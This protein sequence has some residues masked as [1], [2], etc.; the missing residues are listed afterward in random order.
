MT[1][2]AAEIVGCAAA[3]MT[4]AAQADQ[5]QP[6]LRALCLPQIEQVGDQ[7]NA[8]KITGTSAVPAGKVSFYFRWQDATTGVGFGQ[9]AQPNYVAP[10]WTPVTVS[11]VS[12]DPDSFVVQDDPTRP[13]PPSGQHR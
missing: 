6:Y 13:G 10:Y 3:G 8:T 4:S 9:M 12:G 5:P 1:I 2:G 7:L 11:T